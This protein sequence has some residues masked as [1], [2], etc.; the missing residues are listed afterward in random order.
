MDK[1][2][3]NVKMQIREEYG[4]LV[5]TYTCHNK[6][7]QIINKRIKALKKLKLLLSGLS[8]AGF[9]SAI[10]S[11]EKIVAV[12]GAIVSTALFVITS[13]LN[14]ENMACSI[15][16][17]R[18][19]AN[20]L[21]LV[22]ENYI[23]LL[24]EFDNLSIEEILKRRDELLLQTNKI[25][26]SSPQTSKNAYEMTQEVLKNNQEQYFEDW[27]IDLMLPKSLRERSDENGK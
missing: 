12:L 18:N 26:K 20:Q 22:R 11:N 7:A 19:A 25:Y 8:T 9:A 4:K 27:E 17:H 6:E 2:K 13:I 15:A 14:E 10:F 21:W 3:K 23:S 24:S 16:T 1:V 5:Y